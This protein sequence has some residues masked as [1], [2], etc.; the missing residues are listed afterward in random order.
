MGKLW[1]TSLLGRRE[2][3]AFPG[4]ER[5]SNMFLIRAPK[6]HFCLHQHLFLPITSQLFYSLLLQTSWGLPLNTNSHRMSSFNGKHPRQRNDKNEAQS[7]MRA[8]RAGG[9]ILIEEEKSKERRYRAQGEALGLEE[10][11]EVWA[12][13]IM[14]SDCGRNQRMLLE[15]VMPNAFWCD[16]HLCK[17]R[18]LFPG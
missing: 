10:R 5:Q 16:V 18:M 9:R 8:Q 14:E 17:Q 11:G 15:R 1:Q 4:S 3:T 13:G 2:K 12:G 7:M 6:A